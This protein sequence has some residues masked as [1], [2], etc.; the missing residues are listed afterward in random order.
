[1]V[2]LVGVVLPE[3]AVGGVVHHSWLSGGLDQARMLMAEV[4]DKYRVNTCSENIK[5]FPIS[6]F[7]GPKSSLEK[8]YLVFRPSMYKKERNIY[9]ISRR[10][11]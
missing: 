1:M 2:E 8:G 9:Q 4:G 5:L 3:L 11:M 6:N 10:Q 7:Q